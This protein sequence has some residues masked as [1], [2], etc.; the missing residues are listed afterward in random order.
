MQRSRRALLRPLGVTLAGLALS[1][2]A[3]CR[4]ADILPRPAGQSGTEPVPPD[5]T[6]GPRS[7]PAQTGQDDAVASLDSAEPIDATPA[8]AGSMAATPAMLPTSSTP[9]P[10]LT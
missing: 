9:G 1:A 7:Q 4:V 8:P 2:A 10:V 3:G 5:A 6:P